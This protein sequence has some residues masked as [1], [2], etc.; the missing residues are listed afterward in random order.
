MEGWRKMMLLMVLTGE[1]AD[2]PMESRLLLAREEDDEERRKVVRRVEGLRRAARA[3]KREECI[4][5]ECVEVG[6]HRG[7]SSGRE[8][9]REVVMP[10]GSGCWRG[11]AEAA[12]ATRLL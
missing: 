4:L 10:D 3:W 11:E 7:F 6:G 5:G 9:E 1:E 8:E 12:L 2:E